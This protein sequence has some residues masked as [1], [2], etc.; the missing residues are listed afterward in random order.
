MRGHYRDHTYDTEATTL[1]EAEAQRCKVVTLPL[2]EIE[3]DLSYVT[4][5]GNID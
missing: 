1:I 4:G 3:E 5:Y 2:Q